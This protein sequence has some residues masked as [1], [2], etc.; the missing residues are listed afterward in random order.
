MTSIESLLLATEARHNAGHVYPQAITARGML[1]LSRDA[2]AHTADLTPPEARDL[3]AAKDNA[4]KTGNKD[5]ARES[6]A[7]LTGR[8]ATLHSG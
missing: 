6:I 4:S 1:D 5:K 2:L 8:T 7:R 3:I